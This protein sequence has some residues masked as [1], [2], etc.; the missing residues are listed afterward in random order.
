MATKQ[1]LEKQIEDL[2]AE[3]R[4]QEK[5]V[6]ILTKKKAMEIVLPL[7][8]RYIA[9]GDAPTPFFKKGLN[10]RLIA[11]MEPALRKH[12]AKLRW[13]QSAKHL[14]LQDNHLSAAGDRIFVP[15]IWGEIMAEI[16]DC[17]ATFARQCR[18]EG[19][20]EGA[21]L[22]GRLTRNEITA[23]EFDESLDREKAIR[24]QKHK[25]IARRI[26]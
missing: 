23:D 3:L 11:I 24:R 19:F 12:G 22:L 18:A 21:D 1:E 26:K 13:A 15:I 17:A 8:A 20:K 2:K 6:N 10:E 7:V 5:A 9:T 4:E 16:M 25:D 14:H